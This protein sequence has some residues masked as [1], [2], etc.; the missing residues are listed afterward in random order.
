[1]LK[2]LWIA[3]NLN[4]YKARFL[5][6]LGESGQFD[7][8]VLA[9]AGQDRLGHR[10]EATDEEG[11][12]VV[13]LDVP[14]S[15][16]H[17]RPSVYSRLLSLVRGLRPDVVLMPCEKKHLL[18]IV[19]L[20]FLQK[21]FGFFL[22]TYTHPLMRSQGL[23]NQRL[24]RLM[25]KVMF[26]MYD[27]VIFY[28]EQAMRQAVKDGLLPEAKAAYANNTLDT[29]SIKAVYEFTPPPGKP[30]ILFI[31]RLI[32]SKRLDLL[33]KYYEE[34]KKRVT[35]L[36]LMIIGDGP[37]AAR[38]RTA[39]DKDPD[40]DWKGAIV[41]EGV[42]AGIM[43]ESSLVFIPGHSGLSIVHA[44]CYGRP[45]ATSGAYPGHPPEIAYLK[46][47]WNGL[48]LA[49]DLSR[50]VDRITDFLNNRNLLETYSRNAYETAQGLSIDHWREQM[51]SALIPGEPR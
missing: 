45:Y 18:L 25:T 29:D 9:G 51:T 49:G 37:E 12:R 23:K 15:K 44:F 43:A 40:I 26:R 42:I 33:F 14:K 2:V 4:H 27:R 32:P 38:V 22:V 8:T 30:R 31:G 19:F 16:F 6:R 35:G 24:N 36:K 39:A 17:A 10:A 48:L 46:D 7:M 47:G 1:M 28:T 41:D 3:P 34:F 13:R 20:F 50:D 21:G 11:L 5:K